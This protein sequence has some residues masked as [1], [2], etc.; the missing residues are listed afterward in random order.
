MPNVCIISLDY[1]GCGDILFDSCFSDNVTDFEKASIYK[2]RQK[3]LDYFAQITQGADSVELYVGSNRQDFLFDERVGI[4]N[5]NGSCFTNFSDFCKKNK[6]IFNKLLLADIQNGKPSGTS[7][8]DDR[9]K[10]QVGNSKISIIEEQIKEI[11]NNHTKDNVEFYFFDDDEKDF[12]LPDLAGHFTSSKYL[13]P[14][15]IKSFKLIKYD[16]FLEL[17]ENKQAFSEHLNLTISE[18]LSSEKNQE[19]LSSSSRIL[20]ELLKFLIPENSVTLDDINKM[21]TIEVEPE[22]YLEKTTSLEDNYEF[23]D[24]QINSSAMMNEHCKLF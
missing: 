18:N 20:H 3:L 9:M 4:K 23:N 16:W 17:Y 14:N 15:N 1:D 21:N 13:L 11:Q 5:N 6:W 19:Q 10:C 22:Y 7:M 2:V 24:T 12:I 8:T